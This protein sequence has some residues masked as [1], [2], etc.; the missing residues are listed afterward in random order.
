MRHPG[1][2]LGVAAFLVASAAC[3]GDRAEPGVELTVAAAANLSRLMPELTSAFERE[4]GIGV[5]T[6]IGASGQLA[7]QIENGAPVD[8]ILSADTGW[9][10]A[11][12]RSGRTVVGTRAT[13]A[14]GRLVV[15]TSSA[16]APPIE[17]IEDLGRPEVKRIAIANPEH[18]PYGVA[19]REALMSAGVWSVVEAKIIFGENARQ[20][21]QFAETGNVDAA[22][23][24]HAL[25]VSGVGRVIPVPDSLHSPL[26]QGLAVI[27]GRPHEPEA[28][29]F[30]EFVLGAAGRAILEM[31]GFGLPYPSDQ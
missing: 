15:L 16:R 24:P 14:I 18:A 3:G 1:L 2:R 26:M 22:F 28:R 27:A 7:R 10:G 29:R 12:E 21:L 20:V 9:V 23:G 5:T 4:T 19:A 31:Y 13:Y 11:L 25:V 17:R 6:T 30:A 8:V